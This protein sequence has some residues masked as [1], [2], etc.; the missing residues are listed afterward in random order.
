MDG[1]GEAVAGGGDVGGTPLVESA[2]SLLQAAEGGGNLSY[3]SY[4]EY[5]RY[6]SDPDK[7][8]GS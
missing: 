8:D 7:A 2:A 6:Y 5:G 4:S 3:E 1:G